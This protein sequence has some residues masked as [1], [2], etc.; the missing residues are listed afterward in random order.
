MTGSEFTTLAR[1]IAKIEDPA[2]RRQTYEDAVH[3]FGGSNPRFDVYKFRAA[4][5]VS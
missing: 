2:Q 4:C 1:I 5:K 3:E